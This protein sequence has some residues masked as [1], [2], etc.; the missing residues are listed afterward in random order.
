VASAALVLVS[1][2]VHE[3]SGDAVFVKRLRPRGM[4]DPAACAAFEREARIGE[5]LA[6]AGA[7]VPR[8]VEAGSDQLGAYLVTAA[9]D[10]QPATDALASSASWRGLA[11]AA[12][13]AL[14]AVH[15]AAD[16]L[17]PLAVVHRD[18]HLDNVLFTGDGREAWLVDF[19]LASARPALQGTFPPDDAVFR[20]TV[21]YAS[22]ESARGEASTES[23]DRF[24]LAAA[25]L[26]RASGV[27]PRGAAS[28]PAE[29]LYRAGTEPLDAWLQSIGRSSSPELSALSRAL[30]PLLAFD[31][32]DRRNGPAW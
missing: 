20:G 30:A 13:A 2:A 9:I 3:A 17:G 15:R 28:A 22:P 10:G 12:F 31:A 7:P 1:R 5:A 11:R 18:V 4:A 8:F 16:E 32:G 29:L 21:R 26:H 14:E 6:R 25:L 19:G 27:D 23:S 24:S